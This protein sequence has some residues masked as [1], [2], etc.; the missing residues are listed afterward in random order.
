MF[1]DKCRYQPSS[2]KLLSTADAQTHRKT[3]VDITQRSMVCVKLNPKGYIYTTTPA[4]I[5]QGKL[6]KRKWK[7]C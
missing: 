5:D 4:S 6:Q 3:N 2:N 7:G 1:P